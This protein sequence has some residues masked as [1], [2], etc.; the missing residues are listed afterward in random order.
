MIPGKAERQEG[1]M[2]RDL[3][4]GVGKPDSLLGRYCVHPASCLRVC[5]T[6]LLPKFCLVIPALATFFFLLPSLLYLSYPFFQPQPSPFSL[7]AS[8]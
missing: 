1:E 8:Y 5:G 3:C 7:R 6:T 2:V 4:S